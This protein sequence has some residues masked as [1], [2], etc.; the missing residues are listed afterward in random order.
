MVKYLIRIAGFSLLVGR[1]RAKREKNSK[2]PDG[3]SKKDL[4]TPEKGQGKAGPEIASGRKS[5]SLH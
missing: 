5:K 2:R 4:G 3:W 1:R